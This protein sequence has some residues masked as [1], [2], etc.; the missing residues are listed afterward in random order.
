[1]S[2]TVTLP[3]TLRSRIAGVARRAR[4]LRALRGLSLLVLVLA[5]TGGAALLADFFLEDGLPA[6]ARQVNFGAWL[7]LGCVVALFSLLMPLA[8]RLRPA[9]VAAAVEQHYP[10]LGE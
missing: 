8:R 3:R 4:L 7:G 9:D 5:V 2:T 1:M 6:L 10:D